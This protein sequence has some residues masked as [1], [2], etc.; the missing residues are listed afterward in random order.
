MLVSFFSLEKVFS[1]YFFTYMSVLFCLF[2]FV[3]FIMQILVCLMLSQKP[4]KW[5]S[6]KKKQKLFSIQL[7]W[8]LLLCLS[9][10]WSILPY[11]LIDY[12]FLLMYFSLQVLYFSA[13]IVYFYILW[14]LL[15]FSLCSSIILLRSVSIFMMITLNSLWID[16]L[17]F[18]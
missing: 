10:C 15:K 9:D 6:L 18:V 3:D 5:Y 7:G 11:Q 8:F 2:S 4:L 16:Y 14:F 13:M 1:Y 17:H 12:G